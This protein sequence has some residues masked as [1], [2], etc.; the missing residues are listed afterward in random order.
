MGRHKKTVLGLAIGLCWFSLY[1][2]VPI[3]PTYARDQGASYEM[4]GIIA[5][6]YGLMQVFG[7]LPLGILSD[8][9]NRRKVFVIAGLVLC[10]LSGAGMWLIHGVTS[11]LIFRSVSGIAATAWVVHTILYVSYYKPQ[12]SA[13]AMGIVSA[14]SVGGQMAATLLGGWLAYRFGDELTFLVGAVGGIAGLLISL[15]VSE[16][17][18]LCRESLKVMDLLEVGTDRVL[19][20]ASILALI[21]QLVSYGTVYGF[22]PIAARNI[23]ANNFELG[24]LPT[25]FMLPGV[26]TTAV[27]G[28]VFTPLLGIKNSLIAGFVAMAAGAAAIPFVSTL[29]TLY[30]SQ[31]LGG[32]G[33]GLIFPLVMELGVNHVAD[34]K[35]ATAMGYLQATYSV[36]MF[37]G[38]VL[39]GFL[40][41]A[42]GLD[43]GFWAIGAIGLAGVAITGL[44]LPGKSTAESAA[45]SQRQG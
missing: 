1:T 16:N 13:K 15:V 23:G 11:L 44:F 20:L 7:R 45:V 43:W 42:V 12:D 26:I 4:I 21:L 40:G 5:G 6:S 29:N 36:G 33:W 18:E 30:F 28:T 27:S 22:L 34:S 17:R 31:I 2:Y 35:R 19:I 25:L 38:P 37:A 41:G 32:F 9:F 14:I 8:K 39:V 10:G 24:L 3:L